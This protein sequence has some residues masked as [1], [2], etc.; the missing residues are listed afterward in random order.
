MDWSPYV[1]GTYADKS[2]VTSDRLGAGLDNYQAGLYGVGEAV[3]ESIGAN[4][5][6]DWMAERRAANEFLAR[7][8]LEHARQDGAVDDWRDVSGLGSGL[9][10]LGG[11]GAQSL[12][13]LAEA[14]VGGL[15][16]RGLM[17][18][19][20]A[21]LGAA[22]EA[23]NA[24]EVARLGSRMATGQTIGAVGASYPSA[25]GDILQNQRE[26]NP[27]GPTDLGMAGL[28]GVPY[29]AL[30][31]FGMEGMIARGLRPIAGVEAGLARRMGINAGLGALGEGASET[32]QEMINQGFGRMAVNP[33]QTLFNDDANKRYIDSFV[34]GAA[35]GFGPG[36]V[37]GMRKPRVE[38]QPDL[39]NRG[40]QADEGRPDFALESY[41]QA[42][43]PMLGQPAEQ[44]QPAAYQDPN[45][46]NI[47]SGVNELVNGVPVELTTDELNR[48]QIPFAAPDTTPQF[49][50]AQGARPPVQ[51]GL[52]FEYTN[53]DPLRATV[54]QTGPS[55]QPDLFG[56]PEQVN[57][58]MG[59][60]DTFALDGGV[61]QDPRQMELNLQPVQEQQP[62]PTWTTDKLTSAGPARGTTAQLP[63]SNFA[64]PKAQQIWGVAQSL[65]AEGHMDEGT[66][67]QVNTLL[68][69]NRYGDAAKRVDAALK[70]KRS[71]DKTIALAQKVMPEVTTGAQTDGQPAQSQ[72]S[73]Q[74]AAEPRAPVASQ[75]AAA[76]TTAPAKEA[77]A[78]PVPKAQPA[79][80]TAQSDAVAPTPPAQ[81]SDNA[82]Q[83]SGATQTTQ[84]A[85]TEQQLIDNIENAKDDKAYQDALDA[86]HEV[87]DN[88]NTPVLDKWLDDQLNAKKKGNAQFRKDVNASLQRV[89]AK[90]NRAQRKSTPVEQEVTEKTPEQ[91]ALDDIGNALAS[92]AGKFRTNRGDAKTGSIGSK[93]ALEIVQQVL[94]SLGITDAVDIKVVGKPEDVGITNPGAAGAYGVTL[95]NGKIV[96][97]ADNLTS[98]IEAFKTIFHELFH[99]GLSKTLGQGSYIQAML[100]LKTDALVREYAE[101]WKKS[102]EGQA[103]KGTM[104]TN[105][106]EALAVEEALADIGE[107]LS[108]GNLGSK[109]LKPFVRSAVQVLASVADAFGL[110]TVAQAI[111]RMS[112]T[113]AEKFVVDTI[114]NSGAE[115]AATLRPARF[116]QG[117]ANPANTDVADSPFTQLMDRINDLRGGWRSTPGL[118]GFLSMDQ[119][120]DRF[121]TMKAVQ[122]AIKGVQVMGARMRQFV[123]V[124][125]DL[126]KQWSALHRSDSAMTGRLNRLFID[127]TLAE[128]WVDGKYENPMLDPRNAHLKVKDAAE[129]AANT[130]EAMRL[131]SEWN[132]LSDAHKALYKD[133]TGELRKQFDA[134][135]DAMLKRIVDGYTDDLSGV[136]TPDEMTKLAKLPDAE[137]TAAKLKHSTKPGVTVKQAQTIE[138]FLADV[139][140]NHTK[141]SEVPGPYFPLTRRGGFVMVKR[142]PN[143]KKL[144]A[145]VEAA[146]TKFGELYDRTVEE[147]GELEAYRKELATAKTALGEAR[148]KLEAAKGNEEDYVVKFYASRTRA[149]REAKGMGL[150]PKEAVFARQ[151]FFNGTDTVSP[152]LVNRL[153]NSIGKQLGTEVSGDVS[154]AVRQFLISALPE[155]SSM[156]SELKRMK[157]HGVDASEAMHSFMAASHKNAWT[158]A[159]LENSVALAEALQ[160]ARASNADDER[161]VGNELAKRFAQQMQYTEGNSLIDMAANMSHFSFL[162]LSVG[163][164][165]QN[166]LQPWIVTL[167]VL[168]ARFGVRRSGAAIATATSE[169]TKALKLAY[170]GGSL[171]KMSTRLDYSLFNTGN[172]EEQLLRDMT[173]EGLIDI[174]IR[175]DRGG[176]F[177]QTGNKLATSIEAVTDAAAFPPHMVEVVNRIAT[178]L[179]AY[180]LS[181]GNGSTQAEAR[182]YAER[183]LQQTQVD[184][185]TENAPRFMNPNAMGG[186]GRLAFQFKRYQ[187]AMAFLWAKTV[188]EAYREVK[189]G[190]M[191][192]ENLR[193][194]IYMSGLTFGTSGLAGLPIAG[195]AA[196]MLYAVSKMDDDDDEKDLSQLFFAGLKD[197]A[198][199]VVSEAVRYGLPTTI[200]VNVSAK[201][202]AGQT[203]DTGM[204]DKVKRAQNGQEM[205][206]AVAAM[207]FGPTGGMVS[208]WVDAMS[209]VGDQPVKSISKLMPIGIKN[210][211]EAGSRAYGDGLTDRKGNTLMTSDEM[212]MLGT[213]AKG[214]GFGESTEVK[215][216]YDARS[217]MLESKD[218]IKTVRDSLLRDAVRARNSGEGMGEVTERIAA[219]NERQ[220]ENRIMPKHIVGS[221]KQERVRQK[222]LVGGVR[223]GKRDA[224]LAEA[225]GLTSD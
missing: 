105:N 87:Y 143:F 204:L 180:R 209:T 75:P 101:R 5:T 29:A 157:V 81:A 3:A 50:L 36:A 11:L 84:E 135:Q 141:P 208:N 96:L 175:A 90:Q 108:L 168:S 117:A 72:P 14:A 8:A 18:G 27:N 207:L 51:G 203:Y 118:L 98:D 187:Q 61:A 54:Q 25:V 94:R 37:A 64:S 24:A 41:G 78:R 147:A 153:S 20:R 21:A 112:Y 201:L 23:G 86:M 69:D 176:M 4:G 129:L 194:L 95:G 136:M 123:E 156:K 9:N 166:A 148:K 213:I 6:A 80:S 68:A 158:I 113:Q 124:P 142:G 116:K 31:A 163:Y 119:I 88:E 107:A 210:A 222:E 162:G 193:G 12:P 151:E 154:K 85:P 56:G 22:R 82:A 178:A 218:K 217:A 52:D 89:E 102:E 66:L 165:V 137:R 16:A 188:I 38:D 46:M 215:S 144:E 164:Y 128:V 32:G 206:G 39:L 47:M 155:R 70:E 174:T 198:G 220:P 171:Q 184:Y 100:K 190:K 33:D 146:R 34:G 191:D 225:Y 161:I 30:N 43:G 126:R 106:Y 133:V 76:E 114:A 91:K 159:R 216:M 53:R 7:Q 97:F 62:D 192:K 121:P 13:Y 127:S 111:R 196:L 132:S 167:P 139:E 110:K 77:P 134:K 221:W 131:R 212:N 197:Y 74:P 93:R 60:P 177:A 19:T 65:V 1:N 92:F 138:Q 115:G 130:K 73:V 79:A 83:G 48:N 59:Q 169:V 122:K 28:G 63:F 103:K 186:M 57:S 149:E 58:P 17:G 44:V 109:D 170:K 71:A 10:Y 223:V 2:S 224:G 183:M 26:E 42:D 202:G 15:A 140:T 120:A 150:D 214:V 200:G 185:T 125:A 182:L 205:V 211:V 181:M 45:Q 67:T 172:G 99:L 160:E 219:F 104:P 173:D 145:E 35:L 195:P 189:A 49:E 199:P 40:G 55:V 179:S 152:A